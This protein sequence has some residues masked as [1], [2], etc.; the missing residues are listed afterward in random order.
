MMEEANRIKTLLAMN[1]NYTENRRR[2]TA[3][4]EIIRER[5]WRENA[6]RWSCLID[7]VNLERDHKDLWTQVNRMLG[8]RTKETVLK[9]KE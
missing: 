2:L 5:W 1:I 6:E 4:R 3:L 8:R 9:L 7:K